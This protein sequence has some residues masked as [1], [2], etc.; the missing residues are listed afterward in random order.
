MIRFLLLVILLSSTSSVF[1]QTKPD[2]FK[3]IRGLGLTPWQI[4]EWSAHVKKCVRDYGPT[5]NSITVS[6]TI[7]RDGMITGDPV[8][9]SPI[10]SDE[11]REDA[12][13]VVNKLH[14]CEPFII[15]PFGR[16]KGPF[17]QPFH[18]PPMEF[19]PEMLAT[20][21]KHFKKCWTRPK[22]GPDVT[23]DLKYKPNGTFTEPPRPLNQ[24]NTAAYSQAADEVIKQLSRCP[25]LNFPQDKY[26]QVQRF[27]WTFMTVESAAAYNAKHK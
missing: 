8:I 21:Q 10:D 13:K 3:P 25:P 27:T 14:Q 6:L 18:F 19:D 22:K 23:V 26:S 7:S 9:E 20:V 11:F 24:K 5:R 16:S 2:P 1:A 15:D 17:I 12:K 4:A